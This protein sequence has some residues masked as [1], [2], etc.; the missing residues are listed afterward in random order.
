MRVRV[1]VRV[2]MQVAGTLT[3]VE[4]LTSKSS[5][6][7]LYGEMPSYTTPCPGTSR[8]RPC[9]SARN[10]MLTVLF[11]WTPGILLLVTSPE[12]TTLMSEPVLGALHCVPGLEPRSSVAL[13]PACRG[14]SPAGRDQ[15]ELLP[16]ARRASL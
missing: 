5:G 11:L 7:I 8:I 3:P 12:M 9:G 2:T 15:G 1:R 16:P 13:E 6:Q 14:P 10:W 4:N